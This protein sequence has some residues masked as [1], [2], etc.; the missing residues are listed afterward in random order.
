MLK[1]IPSFPAI[2]LST[3]IFVIV[4]WLVY[5]YGVK[6]IPSDNFE[7]VL[8]ENEYIEKEPLPVEEESEG[9]EENED[10]DKDEDEEL[11]SKETTEFKAVIQE[12]ETGWL[13]VRQ[14]P[15]LNYEVILKAKP[16]QS[17]LLT[18]EQDEWYKI[19]LEDE[20]FGW[21][22]ASYISKEEAN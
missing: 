10:E 21:V 6:N 17:Y 11:E 8:S 14:G 3:M 5:A 15:G 2:I 4:G 12:T 9:M 16:G 18:E 1:K 7:V 19:E 22:Y 20:E 13:N